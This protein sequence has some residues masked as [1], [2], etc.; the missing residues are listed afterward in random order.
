MASLD[1]LRTWKA[2]LKLFGDPGEEA[3]AL[4]PL[5]SADADTLAA[6]DLIDL[7]EQVEDVG[8]NAHA[9]EHGW[10]VEVLRHAGVEHDIG[11]LL[12]AIGDDAVGIVR[13]KAGGE[14]EVGG[15]DER[16]ET[17]VDRVAATARRRP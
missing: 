13:S 7:V 16:A 15:R 8:P 5:R 1:P 14:D 17:I 2:D 12:A 3:A 10:A 11:R 4:T 9:F 6:A